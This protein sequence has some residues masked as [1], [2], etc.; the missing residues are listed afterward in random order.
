MVPDPLDFNVNDRWGVSNIPSDDSKTYALLLRAYNALRL[1]QQRL[2]Q[3]DGEFPFA[4]AGLQLLVKEE[5]ERVPDEGKRIAV[6]TATEKEQIHNGLR[7][8]EAQLYYLEVEWPSRDTLE[9]VDDSKLKT[10]KKV[11]KVAKPL[12]DLDFREQMLKMGLYQL[13][14]QEAR[15]TLA[16]STAENNGAGEHIVKLLRIFRQIAREVQKTTAYVHPDQWKVWQEEDADLLPNGTMGPELA[17]GMGASDFEWSGDDDDDNGFDELEASDN[18]MGALEDDQDEAGE[19]N[20]AVESDEAGDGS[21][22]NDD[23][24]D[25]EDGG[26][27]V[28]AADLVQ[29]EKTDGAKADDDEMT[30][31]GE[32]ADAKTEQ[33]TV[34]EGYYESDAP[35]TILFEAAGEEGRDPVVATLSD[36]H[37]GNNTREVGGAGDASEQVISNGNGG[38]DDERLLEA[39]VGEVGGAM[40]RL[41]VN[42][43]DGN[44]AS[45]SRASWTEFAQ[46]ESSKWG[47]Q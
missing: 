34:V 41:A 15:L 39:T 36:D 22:D 28:K 40:G 19:S 5:K 18:A 30:L 27:D 4:I 13:R 25:K 29:N 16:I 3:D 46:R 33:A 47:G 6:P 24:S 9:V 42:N 10:T 7:L 12:D 32:G 43:D 35:K 44:P 37:D 14:A 21:D 11:N 45:V 17:E 23:D 26:V 1:H 38:V 31:V 8:M 20:N 2:R